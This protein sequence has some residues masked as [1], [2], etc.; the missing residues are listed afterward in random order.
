MA[1]LFSKVKAQ[2]AVKSTVSKKKETV[3][4]VGDPAT[5]KIGKSVREIIK[6]TGEAKAI[7]AKEKVH[8]NIVKEYA[9]ENFV[10]DYAALGVHPETPF[11]VQNEA[12]ER[13]TFVVQDRSS[14]YQVKDDQK[15]ALVELLGQDAAADLLYE[16]TTFALNR[17]V[18]AV[19]G[20]QEVIEA[21][22]EKAIKKLTDD[23]AGKPILSP[24][25]AELLL[26]VK[27]KTSFKPGTL[28]RL[29]VVCGKD[30]T[31]IS[32]FLEIMGSSATRYIKA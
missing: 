25:A 13:V 11:V 26:D 30:T 3:W 22:L 14:Q 18:L 10:N 15:G 23:S 29:T 16:E 6:L 24:E 1:G 2:A 9:E 19:P 5:D 12:G 31:K 8:K 4:L 20:V 21:A 27:T 7:E 28:D 17:D 32:R